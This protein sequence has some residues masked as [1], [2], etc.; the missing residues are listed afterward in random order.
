MSRNG[1]WSTWATLRYKVSEKDESLAEA[2][3]AAVS[4]PD[5]EYILPHIF[6]DNIAHGVLARGREETQPTCC[7]CVLVCS[8]PK[9][10]RQQLR[11]LL[12]SSGV[13]VRDADGTERAVRPE[14]LDPLFTREF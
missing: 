7:N 13:M 14:Q 2:F 11:K 5:A 6:A 3:E 10:R 4:D 8:G 9:E 1:K 12:H